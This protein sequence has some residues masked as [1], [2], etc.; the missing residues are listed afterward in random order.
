MKDAYNSVDG[1][2]HINHRQLLVKIFANHEKHFTS[3]DEIM[4]FA[5]VEGEP[6]FEWNM[7]TEEER[8][9]TERELKKAYGRRLPPHAQKWLD[10]PKSVFSGD[11]IGVLDTLISEWK[12]VLGAA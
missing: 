4:A 7:E 8:K 1:F 11:F 9:Q 2:I 3:P 10:T 6:F 12:R 5:T